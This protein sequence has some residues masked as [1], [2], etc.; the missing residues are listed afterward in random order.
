MLVKVPK[1]VIVP[2]VVTPAAI[3]APPVIRIPS[4]PELVTFTTDVLNVLEILTPVPVVPVLVM[5]PNMAM[6]PVVPPI[7]PIPEIATPPAELSAT[8]AVVFTPTI[9]VP[10]TARPMMVINPP[11]IKL[12]AL[13]LKAAPLLPVAVASIEIL[14]SALILLYEPALTLPAGTV[15]TALEARELKLTPY[16]VPVALDPSTLT[17]SP[18]TLFAP[19]IVRFPPALITAG[20]NSTAPNVVPPAPRPD[21]VILPPATIKLLDP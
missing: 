8:V 18:A 3:P 1:P 19:R 20:V 10:V 14:P 9:P 4:K 2:P 11:E 15:M 5:L 13:A 6:L 7:E 21:R 12:T 16:I 17:A